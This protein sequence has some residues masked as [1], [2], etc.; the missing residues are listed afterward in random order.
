VKFFSAAFFYTRKVTLFVTQKLIRIVLVKGSVEY[1]MF[2]LYPSKAYLF[3]IL[4]VKQNNDI[5][6]MKK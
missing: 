5:W 1:L 6:K 4:D 3:L 2:V